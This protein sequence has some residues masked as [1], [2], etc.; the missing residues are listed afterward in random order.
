MYRILGLHIFSEYLCQWDVIRIYKNFTICFCNEIK[1]IIKFCF[2]LASNVIFGMLLYIIAPE[3]FHYFNKFVC[4]YCQPN[5][6]RIT[7]DG[8]SDM[9]Y[10]AWN[11]SCSASW[12]ATS[13]LAVDNCSLRFFIPGV[14][15]ITRLVIMCLSRYNV[16]R[17]Y[18]KHFFIHSLIAI[19]R[20]FASDR[21]S[22][23]CT[24][25][26]RM[27]D[28]PYFVVLSQK[29]QILN[30]NT[31]FVQYGRLSWGTTARFSDYLGS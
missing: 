31:D 19:S 23:D 17:C 10:S 13:S 24:N 9:L 21:S 2:Q 5:N 28:L 29:I 27:R 3:S 25:G 26:S 18:C 22:N 15:S 14:I 16:F 4:Q 8:F 11:D 6:M 20:I 1:S 12:Y 30:T 7:N